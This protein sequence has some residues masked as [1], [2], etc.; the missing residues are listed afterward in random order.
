ML[1]EWNKFWVFYS[2]LQ[3]SLIPFA[4]IMQLSGGPLG[5]KQECQSKLGAGSKL[6]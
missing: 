4:Y 6:Q 2:N 3:F 1:Y 5:G